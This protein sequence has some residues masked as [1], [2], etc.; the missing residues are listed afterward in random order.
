MEG[1]T[2][3]DLT[4]GFRVFINLYYCALTVL[5]FFSF[6]TL[7]ERIKTPAGVLA[8]TLLRIGCTLLCI[9][10]YSL[11][12]VKIVVHILVDFFSLHLL[13]RDPVPR[14]AILAV[15]N[16]LLLMLS[17]GLVAVYTA[18]VMGVSVPMTTGEE[19]LMLR[20]APV[21][22][23]S[24][25][26][27]YGIP[28]LFGRLWP[29]GGASISLSR[30]MLLPVSQVLMLGG[31]LYSFFLSSRSFDAS[32]GII[33]AVMVIACVVVDLIFIRVIQ[34]LVQK[35]QLEEQRA[36]QAKHYAAL[37]DQQQ[38]IRALRHDL[39]NHLMTVNI[40]AQKDA[41]QAE[42]YI[43]DLTRQFREMTAIDFCENRTADAVLYGKRAEASASGVAF[44]VDAVLPETIG[45]DELDLMSLLS[46]LIDNALDAAKQ[47]EDKRVTVTLRTE[48]G[49]VLLNVENTV[50]PGT[51]VDPRRTTKAN[52]QMHGLGVGIAEGICRKYHGS[53]SFQPGDRTVEVSAMLLAE[54]SAG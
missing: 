52:K 8:L 36:L 2:I 41:A 20:L 39:A 14:K 38:S 6:L 5:F 10:L 28:S 34:D 45:V 25:L 32:D 54:K 50:P 31:F 9:P 1:S 27:C 24:Y 16:M 49:A 23:L 4:Y 35:K 18:V 40:L 19:E 11:Y 30:F 3:L 46:N 15:F 21:F 17:E 33:T 12:A 13:F 29:K 44:T 37:M 53:L 47:A 42:A 7:K 51:V 26:L 48:A 22:L 43:K